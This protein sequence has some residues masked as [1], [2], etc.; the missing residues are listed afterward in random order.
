M[1]VSAQYFRQRIRA[2]FE[3]NRHVTD[4]RVI[5]HLLLKGRQEYQETMNFWKQRDHVLGKLIIPKGRPQRSFLEKFYEV[6]RA[7]LVEAR[8]EV[9]QYL[10]LLAED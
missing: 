1:N 9:R 4:L 7:A 5:N 8:N 6:T 2:K 10:A 3:E